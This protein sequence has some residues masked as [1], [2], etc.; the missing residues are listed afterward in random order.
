[1]NRQVP[2]EGQK[3]DVRLEDGDWQDAVYA[4]SCLTHAG[5][6]RHEATRARLEA[7]AS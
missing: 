3:V 1:M 6:I 2:I 5:A 4:Q 7:Q